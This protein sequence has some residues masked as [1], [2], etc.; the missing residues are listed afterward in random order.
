[1][2]DV[3]YTAS[4]RRTHHDHRVGCV[5]DGPST[6]PSIS[7]TRS[8]AATAAA[9][10]SRAGSRRRE[11][12]ARWRSSSRDRAR[13]GSAWARELLAGEPVVRDAIRAS[14]TPPSASSPDWSL[15]DELT[16]AEGRSRLDRDR[17]RPAVLFAMQVALAGALAKRGASSPTPWS[18][19]AWAKWPPRTWPARSRCDDAARVICR[20]SRLLRRTSGQG[21][22]AV[23]ELTFDRG[24]RG[25]GRLRRPAVG[26]GEQQPSLDGA[27]GRSR[28][29]R[30]GHRDAREA[31]RS[32]AAASR[33]TWRLTA[34]RWIR[35]APTCW[36]AL[37]G[38]APREPRAAVLFDGDR[39]AVAGDARST[40]AYWV[41]NLRQPVLFSRDRRAAA[42]RTATRRSSR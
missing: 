37:D 30:R 41:R 35:C 6:T 27:V 39:R 7:S 23:V 1:M 28:G 3:C 22:M 2:D 21:A 42:R 11:R 26:R 36:Q 17:R 25:A 34:R 40:P 10:A 9:A 29:A 15:I 38:L 12:R 20:R 32:S 19:T 14:A 8:C 18:A 5:V 31:A 4:V 16:A 33:W 13:S 24:D